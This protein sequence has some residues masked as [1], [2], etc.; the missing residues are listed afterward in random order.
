MLMTGTQTVIRGDNTALIPD[1]RADPIVSASTPSWQFGDINAFIIHICFI[2][3]LINCQKVRL[4]GR[5]ALDR[6]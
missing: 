4:V 5:I 2:Q 6:R 1:Y 3:E